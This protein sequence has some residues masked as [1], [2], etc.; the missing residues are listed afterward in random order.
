M[1]YLAEALCLVHARSVDE[2]WV[3]EDCVTLFHF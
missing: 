3:E 1:Q 2:Q